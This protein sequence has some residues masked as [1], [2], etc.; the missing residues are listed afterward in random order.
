MTKELGDVAVRQHPAAPVE[1]T[2]RGQDRP[3]RT[4][5][6]LRGAACGLGVAG[7]IVVGRASG[8]LDGVLAV[9]LLLLVV[10]AVPVSRELSRRVLVVG[11]LLLGWV[12]VLWWVPLPVGV[13]GRG[14]ALLA[15]VAG[16]LTA[17]VAAGEAPA[18]R[19]R[20]LLPRLRLVDIVPVGAALGTA[21][22]LAPWWRAAAGENAL[23]MLL[24]GWDH[25]AHF[26]M[27]EMIRRHGLV[28]PALGPAPGGETWVYAHYPQGYH[29]VVATFMELVSP[30][31]GPIGDEVLLYARTMAGVVVLAA[32]VLVAGVCA[33]PRLRRAPLLAI[34]LSAGVW[35]V[36]VLGPGGR[37]LS[38]GFPNYLLAC[39]LL[40]SLPLVLLPVVRVASP[41]HVA[42]A[43]AAIAGIAHGWI[44]LLVLAAPTLLLLV[45]PLRRGRWR[46]GGGAWAWTVATGVAVLGSIAVALRT[47]GGQRLDAV[48]VIDGGG[49]TLR[50][51]IPALLV[52]ACLLVGVATVVA[53]RGS[54]ATTTLARPVLVA[55]LPV[56]GGVVALG[57]GWLQLRTT[58]HL[59][60]Y[61]WKFAI[62]WTIFSAVALVAGV[63]GF[64]SAPRVAARP[65]PRLVRASL[66][67]V[68]VGASVLVWGGVHPALP[69][70]GHAAPGIAAR[71]ELGATSLAPPPS[72]AAL[73]AAASAAPASP[74]RR[75]VFVT[76]PVDPGVFGISAAQWYSALTS[77]WTDEGNVSLSRLGG[78]VHTPTDAVNVA[79]VI[80]AADPSAAVVVAPEFRDAV[81][82]GLRGDGWGDRVLSW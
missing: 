77:T 22:V 27:S 40:A 73:L 53:R 58:G 65:W 38:D 59:G 32:T 2:V 1:V 4:F 30:E 54:R 24:R 31:V 46:A 71:V 35:S 52:A 18:R 17:W 56:V 25:S 28:I 51:L 20:R 26:N 68:A 64:V 62:A 66:A 79:R 16:G 61:F 76:T 80:L 12:P 29:A 45:V 70:R 41:V 13:A 44:L 72:A 50:L 48:L 37:I 67:L 10:L 33:L 11:C 21:F 8:V 74:E 81:R 15:V 9:A 42:A 34:A 7:T 43:G 55:L 19:G 63:V 69:S 36:L 3:G 78:D 60:Y 6:L 49:T 82:A 47:V 75:A 14:T 39:V 57:I 23:G 5:R